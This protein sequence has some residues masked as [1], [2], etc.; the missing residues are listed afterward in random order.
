MCASPCL[1]TVS[2]TI[3]FLKRCVKLLFHSYVVTFWSMWSIKSLPR[4]ILLALRLF[5]YICFI[6]PGFSFMCLE[7]YNFQLHLT[8]SKDVSSKQ[9]NLYPVLSPLLVT[10]IAYSSPERRFLSHLAQT[11]FDSETLK[12]FPGGSCCSSRCDCSFPPYRT[13]KSGSKNPH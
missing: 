2:D 13:T 10:G 7:H 9:E 12:S 4:L 1:K 8:L 11:C 6:L 3:Q 5:F